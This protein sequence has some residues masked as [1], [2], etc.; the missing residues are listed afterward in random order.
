MAPCINVYL[1]SF[2]ILCRVPVAWN[3]FLYLVIQNTL[4]ALARGYYRGAYMS[5]STSNESP[6][7]EK[8][9]TNKISNKIQTKI[10]VCYKNKLEITNTEKKL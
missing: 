2:A 9:N 5:R 4:K 3:I 10:E 1:G 8:K 6:K 7:P